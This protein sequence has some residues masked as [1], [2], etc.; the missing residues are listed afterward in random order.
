MMQQLALLS[1]YIP[2]LILAASIIGLGVII[3]RLLTLYWSCRLLSDQQT[4]ELLESLEAGSQDTLH[5]YT[6][7]EQFPAAATAARLLQQGVSE[8]RAEKIGSARIAH[9]DKRMSTLNVIATT[10]PLLGLL[11]TVTGMI[12]SFQAFAA[13][14]T[15][16]SQLMGGVD[17]ALLTTALGLSVALPA[18]ISHNYFTRRIHSLTA[19]T[20]LLLGA[21]LR[22]QCTTA[23]E[24]A[25]TGSM[26]SAPKQKNT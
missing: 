21:V 18:M 12:K 19:Q 13:S 22:S 3:D 9:F 25:V 16:G 7:Q 2:W 23:S 10:A 14:E 11:G 5:S 24:D 17:E 1:S 15:A 8:S 4:E 20:N 6:D 26:D